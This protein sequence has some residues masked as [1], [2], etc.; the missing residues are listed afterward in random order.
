MT[1]NTLDQ[2]HP[3]EWPDEWRK[4]AA[5]GLCI[6]CGNELGRFWKKSDGPFCCRGCKG[7]YEMIH[8]EDLCRFYDIKPDAHSPAPI[9]RPESF[10]WLD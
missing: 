3:D 1:T 5:D 9:L 8:Q 6:H 2:Q 10:G 4:A 7:V